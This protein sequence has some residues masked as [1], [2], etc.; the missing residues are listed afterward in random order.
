MEAMQSLPDIGE[1]LGRFRLERRLGHGGMGVVFL[2]HDTTLNIKVA[3]KV[4]MPAVAKSTA[5]DRFMREVLIARKIAHPSICRLF[6]LHQAGE[7]R[8][9]SMEFVE[10]RTL[11]TI[12]S[13]EGM[14]TQGRAGKIIV[15]ACRAIRVAHKQGVIHRDLK[16]ANIIVRDGVNI[17]IP[18]FYFAICD[19]Y[20]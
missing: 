5:F 20:L 16:P 15:A 7:T 10:G 12:L 9:I 8:F 13:K 18:D 6:D 14:L 1:K 4:F 19:P 17:S 3:L 2:A 11:E